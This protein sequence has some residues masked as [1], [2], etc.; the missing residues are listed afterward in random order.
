MGKGNLCVARKSRKHFARIL[1]THKWTI[2]WDA[3]SV[4]EKNHAD[5]IIFPLNSRAFHSF[6]DND[7]RNPEG[8]FLTAKNIPLKD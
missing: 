8:L 2:R 1:L 3:Q 6:K 4:K 7:K 5:I